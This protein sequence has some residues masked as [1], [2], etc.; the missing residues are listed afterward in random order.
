MAPPEGRRVGFA[1]LLVA[2]AP[3]QHAEESDRLAGLARKDVGFRILGGAHKQLSAEIAQEGWD[4]RN[5]TLGTRSLH[6]CRQLAVS[7]LR[8]QQAL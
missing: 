7:M 8:A 6:Q 4:A 1:V 2:V 3:K 5:H